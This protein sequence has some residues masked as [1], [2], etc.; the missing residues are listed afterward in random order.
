MSEDSKF[1]ITV[2]GAGS[3]GTA[4]AALLARHDYPTTL[5]GRTAAQIETIDR[6]HENRP[7]VYPPGGSFP[8]RD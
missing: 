5:W 6:Q 4:L 3:W 7:A 2:L 8:G 1:N